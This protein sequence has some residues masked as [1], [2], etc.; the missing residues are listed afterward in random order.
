MKANQKPSPRYPFVDQ[1]RGMAVLLMIIFHTAYDLHLFK[2]AHIDF[3]KDILWWSFP[4]VIVFLFLSAVGLSLP[5]AHPQQIKWSSFWKRWGKLALFAGLISLSTYQ[6]FPSRWVYFGTLHC[7]ATC[8]LMALPL[9]YRPKLAGLLAG[10]ILGPLLFGFHYPWVKLNQPSMDY[11]PALP[12]VSVVLGGIWAN[13][14]NW[15]KV[16]LPPNPFTYFLGF[17]GR[18]SLW[19][20]L[21]HQPLLYGLFYTV[22][23]LRS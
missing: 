10:L 1:I 3:Q 14:L 8:S 18:W 21:V 4:R 7:I 6:L 19:I 12:W 20:Y 15:H 11:I 16:K 13:S 9:L 5:L 2:Y 22:T 23:A 17:L